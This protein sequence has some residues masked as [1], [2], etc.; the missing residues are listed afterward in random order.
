MSKIEWTNKTWNPLAGCKE[1]S[2][3][4]QNCYAAV[5][6]H[7]LAAMGQTKYMG[8]TRKLDNGKVVWTGTLALDDDALHIPLRRRTPTMYFVNSMS[9]LFHEDVDDSFID[10]V[11]AVMKLCPQHTFQVLTKR[12]DRMCRYVADGIRNGR[13]E[14]TD[15]YITREVYKLAEQHGIKDAEFLDSVVG[16]DNGWPRNTWAGVSVEDQQRADER[17]PLL[18]QTPAA[19][20]FLSCEPLLG[21]VD[22]LHVKWPELAKPGSN[23]LEPHRL[24]VL[25][26]GYWSKQYGFVNHSDMHGQFGKPIQWVI[27]GGESGP[28]ARP[29]NI[30]WIRSIVEQCKSAVVPVFVK[31][32]GGNVEAANDEVSDWFDAC[33]RLQL[34][35]T[36][37][38]QG[39][40]GRVTGFLDRKGGDMAEW[41]EYLRVR[42]FPEVRA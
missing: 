37:R 41:P 42:E 16:V 6:A 36:E 19:V 22:L 14:H 4:C 32:L 9:D 28:G 40:V 35:E 7:R 27:V 17:I 26:F 20:R 15:M 13:G 18:L 25:R 1:V 8:T 31:Q 38:F 39:A 12:P 2:P 30:D 29:C 23:G 11:F 21:P 10:R 5:M 24:D 33:G 34:S 3:G